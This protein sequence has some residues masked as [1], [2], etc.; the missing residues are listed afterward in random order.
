MVY[1]YLKLEITCIFIMDYSPESN[2]INILAGFYE[3]EFECS[4]SDCHD[5][6][7][8]AISWYLHEQG[9]KFSFNLMEDRKSAILITDKTI[10]KKH[11]EII[12]LIHQVKSIE[13][14][15]GKFI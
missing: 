15:L 10:V 3:I 13:N 12:P 11:L 4:L 8:N 14:L 6:F 9:Y 5:D 1:K 2:E 7:D